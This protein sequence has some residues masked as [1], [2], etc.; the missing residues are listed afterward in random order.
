MNA[1]LTALLFA[2]VPQH[3]TASTI[4]AP[5]SASEQA[6]DAADYVCDGVDDQ[7]ELLASIT[8]AGR[9]S[10]DFDRS[11]YVMRPAECYGRHSVDWLPGDYHLGDTLTIPDTADFV[12]RAEGTFF[13]YEPSTGDAVLIMGLTRC[14]FGFGTIET[15]STGAALRIRPESA[16]PSLTSVVGFTGLIGHDQ[17]GTGFHIDS[18]VENVCCNRFEG[19]DIYHFDTGVDLSEPAANDGTGYGCADSNWSWFNYIRR[20]RTGVREGRGAAVN[21]WEMNVDAGLTDS[22]AVRTGG[23]SGRWGI[24]AGAQPLEGTARVLVLDPG[25]E[26][27]MIDLQPTPKDGWVEDNSGNDTNIIRTTRRTTT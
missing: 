20:C 2:A 19:T 13:H 26:G 22:V 10:V 23:R 6:K 11:P 18:A 21:V 8:C 25:A 4:V 12:I 17:R 24:V 27:N 14:R 7:V 5:S 15:T 1:A 16:M 9:F 3:Q